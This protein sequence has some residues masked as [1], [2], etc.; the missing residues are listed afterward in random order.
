MADE[1]ADDERQEPR[2][3]LRPFPMALNQS[4]ATHRTPRRNIAFTEQTCQTVGDSEAF[5]DDSCQRYLLCW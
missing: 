5:E 4:R 1:N 3:Q 2:L